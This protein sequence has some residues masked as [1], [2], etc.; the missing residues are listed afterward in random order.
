MY[1]PICRAD[2]PQI[3]F[4]TQKEKYEK[5]NRRDCIPNHKYKILM[6]DEAVED[7]FEAL[8]E[9][10]CRICEKGPLF[11]NFAALQQHMS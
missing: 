11:N 1:C 8:L 7:A 10:R 6:E 3:V 4:L 9:H 5:V 2:L